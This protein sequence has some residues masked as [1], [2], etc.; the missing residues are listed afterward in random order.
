MKNYLVKRYIETVNPE[1]VD[2]EDREYADDPAKFI[3]M[4]GMEDM[5]KVTEFIFKDDDSEDLFWIRKDNNGFYV[6]SYQCVQTEKVNE[7]E[8]VFELFK[9]RLI[10]VEA[11][12]YSSSEDP[13]YNDNEFED[14]LVIV[15]EVE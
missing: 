1:Q 10:E 13:A 15:K 4:Y 9:Y 2:I 11:G 3:E 14:C 5:E 12:V 6:E 8:E 7:E